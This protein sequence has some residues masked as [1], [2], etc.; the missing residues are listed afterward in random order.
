MLKEKKSLHSTASISP[1]DIIRDKNCGRGPNFGRSRVTKREKSQ[2]DQTM[3][4]KE[5]TTGRWYRRPPRR[6][7]SCVLHSATVL[8]ILP[9]PRS[10]TVELWGGRKG[11]FLPSPS[12]RHT[13]IS[14]L[15]S[16]LLLILFQFLTPGQG[17]NSFIQT[18]AKILRVKN[19][20]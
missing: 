2:W 15:P 9:T 16:P 17:N 5:N 7:W 8:L 1:N 18:P 6:L 11:L 19:E 10:P 4:G 14:E 3:Q 12:E 13:R 20:P